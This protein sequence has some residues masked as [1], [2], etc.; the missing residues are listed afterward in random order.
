MESKKQNEQ[1]KLIDKENRIVDARG[2]AWKVS[3]M[4]EGGQEK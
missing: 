2:R 3:N 4:S 1:T